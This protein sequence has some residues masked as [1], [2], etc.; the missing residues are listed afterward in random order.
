M[1]TGNDVRSHQAVTDTYTSGPCQACQLYFV[2]YNAK[3]VLWQRT[4]TVA[5]F[6][7]TTRWT[8]FHPGPNSGG[9]AHYGK[10]RVSCITDNTCPGCGAGGAGCP[11]GGD[12]DCFV[13]NG[14]PGCENVVCCFQVCADDPFC[15]D[16]VWDS[17]CAIIALETCAVCGSDVRIYRYGNDRVKLPAIMGHEIAGRVVEAG[18]KVSRVKVG[19]RVALGADVPCG[20]CKWCANGMG[21]NCRINYAIGYQF[22]GGFQQRM[23]L[24]ETVLRYGPV[25]RIPDHVGSDILRL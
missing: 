6:S 18:S 22:P 19:D 17:Q 8:S 24:N 25:T 13:P 16:V 4:Y 9:L 10:L 20:I 21:T 23:L 3:L 14:T 15:C 7:Y 2:Y 5:G 1:R 12:G 11:P